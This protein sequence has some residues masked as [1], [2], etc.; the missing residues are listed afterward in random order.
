MKRVAPIFVLEGAWDKTHETPQVLP[1][2]LAY[3]QSHRCVDLYHRT[4]R[5]VEDISYYVSRVSTGKRAFFYFACH[6][7]E[8]S[9]IPSDGRSPIPIEDV[10]DA[11][12]KAKD[13]G[14]AFVHFG[15][16]HFVQSNNR[17]QV[18]SGLRQ[19]ARARWVS[20]Y[21]REVDWLASTLL[22]LALISEVY[23]PWYESDGKKVTKKAEAFF[24]SYE[25]LARSLGFSGMYAEQ[26]AERLFPPRITGE[27]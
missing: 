1:Y 15:C 9:L 4:F 14:I 3:A 21:T 26:K 7:E 8:G 19:A 22:D 27:N 20:G 16:C 17:R 23:V 11:L 24:T 10:E 6:G 2:L 25:Q 12:K 5:C 13:N 18:L